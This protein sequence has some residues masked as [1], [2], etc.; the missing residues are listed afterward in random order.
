MAEFPSIAGS[1]KVF[2]L[3][4][5]LGQTSYGTGVPVMTF[6]LTPET[7][8]GCRL[9]HRVLVDLPVLHDQVDV[10]FTSIKILISLLR[11]PLTRMISA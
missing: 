6:N 2:E 11:S 7:Q 1:R 9:V 4:I 10:F 3:A 8:I 5:D